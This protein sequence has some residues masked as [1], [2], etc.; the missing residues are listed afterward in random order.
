MTNP[1][2]WTPDRYAAIRALIRSTIQ[3]A[4]DIAPDQ[5]P[6]HVRSMIKDHVEGDRDIDAY[7][8]QVLKEEKSK[9]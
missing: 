2:N 5:L 6:H 4:G 3:S 8:A 9:K 1:S 7:I